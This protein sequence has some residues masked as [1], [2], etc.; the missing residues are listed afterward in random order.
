MKTKLN[1]LLISAL[2]TTVAYAQEIKHAKVI[3]VSPIESLVQSYEPRNVCVKVQVPVYKTVPYQVRV[4]TPV[5]TY[6]ETRDSAAPILGML[7]GAA[8]GNR[9][10]NGDARF[11]GTFL[12]ASV[13]YGLASGNSSHQAQVVN[14]TS[15]VTEFR[16][17]FQGV[18]I[19]DEC[20]QENTLVHKNIT[21]G[22][23]VTYMLNG[24]NRTVVMNSH[25][26]EYVR[27]ITTTT[28][29]P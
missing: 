27:V 15:Y 22:Y 28:V 18:T 4:D 17:E 13:G 10:F 6:R 3:S 8:I 12:G 14:Q 5:V 9:V 25:P 23:N 2:F 11:A 16:R 24:V 21:T 29:E 1:F 26:G 20:R 19:Q 7:V